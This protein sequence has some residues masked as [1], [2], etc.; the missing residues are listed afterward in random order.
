MIVGNHYGVEVETTRYDAGFG[1]VF[2]GDGKNNFKFLSATESGF[3][4]PTDARAI[5][6]ITVHKTPI[7]VVTN[8]NT[9]L[10]VFKASGK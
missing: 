10:S 9:T 6:P 5:L 7:F 3:Y 2:L 1:G 4:T 8:N